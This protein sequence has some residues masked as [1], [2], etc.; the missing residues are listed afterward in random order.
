MTSN[1]NK[2]ASLLKPLFEIRNGRYAIADLASIDLVA[3]NDSDDELFLIET[4]LH[5]GK[6]IVGGMPNVWLNTELIGQSIVPIVAQNPGEPI[7]RC[8]GT[9]FFVSCTGFLITAAHVILDPI[10]SKYGGAVELPGNNF[11]LTGAKN[12]VLVP[13]NSIFAG[14]KAWQFRPFEWAEFLAERRE[15]PIPI[16]GVDLKLSSD[17]AVCKVQPFPD[18]RPFQPLNVVQQGIMGT[19]F[20]PGKKAFAVGYGGMANAEISPLDRRAFEGDFK[21][22][23]FGST[24]HVLEHFPENLLKREVSAPGPCFSATLKLPGGMSGS[25]I[26]D[27]EGIYV[28]GVV[29]KGSIDETGI[30]AFGYGCMLAPSLAMPVKFLNGSSIFELLKSEVHGM[31]KFSGP[32]L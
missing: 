4:N 15:L 19:G 20:E 9:G 29:S 25:P 28:H 12:G 23:L 16:K 32:G 31:A 13:V 5:A 24:G 2:R 26:F 22:D 14:M 8:L 17:I 6:G 21:F 27:D 3:L 18:G 10:E 11:Q 30:S 1:E 7:L